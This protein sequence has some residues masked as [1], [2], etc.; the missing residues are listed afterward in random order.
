M[1]R[2]CR[3]KGNVDQFVSQGGGNT[4]RSNFR[5]KATAIGNSLSFCSLLVLPF[6]FVTPHFTFLS[7]TKHYRQARTTMEIDSLTFLQPTNTPTLPEPETNSSSSLDIF[8]RKR[9]LHQDDPFFQEGAYEYK[10]A[11]LRLEDAD[12]YIPDLNE[13]ESNTHRTYV[14]TF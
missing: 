4:L 13:P 12:A 1:S 11:W 6:F 9:P 7:R 8:P 14:F 10:A 5:D 3:G 2:V